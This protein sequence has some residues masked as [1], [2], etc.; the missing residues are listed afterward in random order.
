[1]LQAIRKAIGGST[2]YLIWYSPLLLTKPSFGWKW[3]QDFHFFALAKATGNAKGIWMLAIQYFVHIS[4][5][6]GKQRLMFWFIG[7]FGPSGHKGGLCYEDFGFWFQKT[8]KTNESGLI[9]ISFYMFS[10]MHVSNWLFNSI[11]LAN[12]RHF[13]NTDRKKIVTICIANTH[14]QHND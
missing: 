3:T 7:L 2:H 14:N 6:A 10:P 8:T 5:G 9:W 4:Q 12:A 1:V 11:F 13:A